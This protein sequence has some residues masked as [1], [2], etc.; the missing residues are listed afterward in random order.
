MCCR[1]LYFDCALFTYCC[2]TFHPLAPPPLARPL[3]PL[4]SHLSLLRPTYTSACGR[5]N[6]VRYCDADVAFLREALDGLP[7]DL[8]LFPTPLGSLRGSA[9]A[10][11]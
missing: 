2:A 4:T 5:T 8:A 11:G 1:D 9:C 7:P 3:A 6:S 10:S